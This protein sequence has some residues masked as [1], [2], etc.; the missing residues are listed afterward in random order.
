MSTC[1]VPGRPSAGP[2]EGVSSPASPV[3]R[4]EEAQGARERCEG[5]KEGESMAQAV[6]GWSRWKRTPTVVRTVETF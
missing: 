6:G 5:R 4:K 1:C 3:R 2:G